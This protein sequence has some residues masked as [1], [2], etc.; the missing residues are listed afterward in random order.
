M[1]HFKRYNDTNGHSA[2]DDLLQQASQAWSE[3]LHP[4]GFLA[5]W[6]GEEFA[7]ALPTASPDEALALLDGLRSVVPH[8]QTCSIGVARWDGTESPAAMLRRAD[9]ALYE[10]KSGGRN[11][12]VLR[13]D[14]PAAAGI[15]AQPP[16]VPRPRS[17]AQLPAP[18]RAPGS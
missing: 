6:G 16:M 9:Q 3:A 18:Q 5:R 11:R 4:T 1:D 2:G 15:P 10:A 12:L 13:E 17:E 7:V 14:H 8:A